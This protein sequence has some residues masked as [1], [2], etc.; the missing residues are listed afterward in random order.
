MEKYPKR[1]KKTQKDAE[2]EEQQALVVE[3]TSEK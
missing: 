1:H 2:S 3:S